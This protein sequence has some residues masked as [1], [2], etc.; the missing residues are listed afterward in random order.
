[1]TGEKW[2]GFLFS[3][4]HSAQLVLWPKSLTLFL[5]RYWH[6]PSS[7]PFRRFDRSSQ[8]HSSK[9][10]LVFW[11]PEPEGPNSWLFHDLTWLFTLVEFSKNTSSQTL[12][13]AKSSRKYYSNE[14]NSNHPF[15]N[16]S[17]FSYIRI[18]FVPKSKTSVTFW[19]V[20]EKKCSVFV[21]FCSILKSRRTYFSFYFVKITD[22]C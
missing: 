11:I 6:V 17:Q 21:T 18:L 16:V 4:F 15:W 13:K 9:T 7:L 1:M 2:L 8:S 14:C 12:S 10:C 3:H 20:F 22:Q 5:R 19:D